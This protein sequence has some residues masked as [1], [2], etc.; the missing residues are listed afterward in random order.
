MKKG[1][2]TYAYDIRDIR[3]SFLDNE[4]EEIYGT[5]P[6]PEKILLA[7]DW[8]LYH[9]ISD[10]EPF[11]TTTKTEEAFVLKREDD[12]EYI[13]TYILININ[14]KS[15]LAWI[16]EPIP[17]FELDN[18]TVTASRGS[19][20]DIKNVIG[21]TSLNLFGTPFNARVVL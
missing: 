5:F 12:N 16:K 10:T 6:F 7:K 15:T 11:F 3:S 14:G 1:Q 4:E 17:V 9:N 8:K 13:Y 2:R 20:P 21:F 18:V 19:L